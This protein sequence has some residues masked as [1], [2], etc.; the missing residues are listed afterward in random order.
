M[1]AKLESSQPW[2]LESIV[3]PPSVKPHV[4]ADCWRQ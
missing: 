1:R 4:G 2:E 3:T